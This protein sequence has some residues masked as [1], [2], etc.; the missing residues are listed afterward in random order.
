M[1]T[2][3]EIT[4]A[5]VLV[6]LILSPMIICPIWFGSMPSYELTQLAKD[7]LP[8]VVHIRCPSWQGSGFIIGKHLIATARHVTEGVED[9]EITQN[10]GSVIHSTKA[11]S[12]ED[13]DVSI[14]W[15]DEE[16]DNI[17]PLA[18]IKDCE[19][20]QEVFV[21]GSPYGKINF[22]C[23]TSGII[24]GLGRDWSPL[25]EHYGWS[26]TWTT[27]A[28]GHPGNSGGPILT[29]DGK[30]RG[31]LVGGFS[32]VLICAM[33]VDLFMNDIDEI[34]RMF[35]Q[36]KYYKEKIPEMSDDPYYNEEL[37]NEYY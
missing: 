8:G 4:V 23:L 10:D 24:S 9:F 31:I 5:L 22:N 18:S 6:I 35:V 25:G 11:I 16:L 30:V 32:P 3:K 28:V 2:Y 13:Y 17:L 37:D 36:D 34:K 14:I 27:T 21:V 33:P 29:Y 1:S 15:V 26:V 12:H 19:I 20:G 7:T